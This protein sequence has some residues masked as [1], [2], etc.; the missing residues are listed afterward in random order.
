LQ[1]CGETLFQLAGSLFYW[2]NWVM[3]MMKEV[4]KKV[5]KMV[6]AKVLP[7]QTIEG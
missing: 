3:M 6:N 4:G 2:I 5:R 1:P 7:T